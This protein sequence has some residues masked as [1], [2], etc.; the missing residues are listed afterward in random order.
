MKHVQN[1]LGVTDAGTVT[2]DI[3]RDIVAT[4]K[5]MIEALKKARDD[6]QEPPDSKPGKGGKGGKPGDQKLLELLAELKMVRSLQKRINDRTVDRARQFPGE[7]ANDP[8][9]VREIRA[10][11]ER[12]L[13]IQEIVANIVK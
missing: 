6:N 1:R 2:Q 3:E 8:Q 10:L 7:Q 13:R 11:G 5:E 4:L 12:Q 9:V